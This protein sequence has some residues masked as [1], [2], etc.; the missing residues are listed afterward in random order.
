MSVDQEFATCGALC[1][2]QISSEVGS[3]SC[4]EVGQGGCGD[5]D[6]KAET[7]LEPVQSFDNVLHGHESM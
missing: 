5:D 7:K 6:D 4:V 2:E 3:G 1:T